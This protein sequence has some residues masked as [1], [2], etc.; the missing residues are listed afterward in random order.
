M[1]VM[2][3]EK[4]QKSISSYTGCGPQVW[5]DSERGVALVITLL[6]LFLMSVMGL[7][8]VVTSSSDLLINGYYRNF[9]G[10]FYAADSGLIVAR[11]A[12]YNQTIAAAPA[13]FTAGTAPIPTG[14][15]AAVLA[16]VTSTGSGGYGSWSTLNTTGSAAANS[17]QE[18]FRVM[19]SASG[20]CPLAPGSN[21]SCYQLAAGSPTWNATT[22]QY[23]YTYNYTLTAQGRSL[24]VEQATVAESGMLTVVATVAAASGPTTSFA[25]F[26][27]FIDQQSLC[28]GSYL[29]PGTI[30]GPVFTNGGWTFGTAGSYI[31]TD[32]AGSA[33]SKAGF[34]FGNCYQSTNGSY[35]SGGQT[36]S[37]NYQGGYKWG[38]GTMSLP[39]NSFSQKDAVLDG[40]G[41]ACAGVSGTC[42]SNAQMNAA[43]KNASTGA[44]YPSS[45]ASTG[46]FLPYSGSPATMTGGGILV[47]GNASV[48]LSTSGTSGQVYTI[49]QGSGRTQTTTTITVDSSAN[50][51]AGTTTVT[52]KIGSGSPSTTTIAGVPMNNIATPPQPGTMLYVDG[53]ITSLSGPSSGAAIQNGSQVTVTATSDIDI[54][55][56]ILYPAEPVT[57]TQQ[58]ST[59]PDTLIPANDTKEVLG[60]FTATGNINLDASGSTS[61]LEIDASL[62]AI[63]QGG[64]GGLTN[65]GNALNTLTIVGGRIQST[66][67]N[68][69]T[70]T[71]N[72][73]F[74]RRFASGN[75]AP[76]WFPST[77]IST[78][79]TN[80]ASYGWSFQKVQWVSSS[81]M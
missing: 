49:V 48:T 66:I 61:N 30:S 78:P 9:R 60:I 79:N 45:G 29:V 63:S 75:F 5:G 10:S 64:S 54:T 41:L 35:S 46:V 20:S 56:N 77:S 8:A 33:N 58:G 6:L 47:E 16:A 44:A 4:G 67:Q 18:Q 21:A 2:P 53:T 22:Q 36:I 69:N 42:P 3:V 1:C 80:S 37:P 39:Q 50:S 11:Q 27:M 81:S 15:D 71:R 38:Q 34:Q 12:L 43:L 68:I 55:G 52:T 59:P 51:G 70:T 72:V 76:P 28:D 26:G 73:M 32:Q 7:A 25:G 74:D 40:L 13:T 57:L 65:I 62:A 23:T 31:F 19:P 24:G 17:W 14:T